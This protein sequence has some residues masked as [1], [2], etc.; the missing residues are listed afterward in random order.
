LTSFPSSNYA[1]FREIHSE[2]RIHGKKKFG[3][4]VLKF[5]VK[6]KITILEGEESRGRG[7]EKFVNSDDAT[8]KQLPHKIKLIKLA[9]C[10]IMCFFF[11]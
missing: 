1:K 3:K 10:A 8:V 6:G 4:R 11:T 7:R 2:V 5:L 9:N